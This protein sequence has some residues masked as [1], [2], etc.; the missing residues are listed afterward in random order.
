MYNRECRR[1]LGDE[2][3][4]YLIRGVG[5]GGRTTQF[6]DVPSVR[7]ASRSA[8]M[9]APTVMVAVE[10][11]WVMETADKWGPSDTWQVSHT[12]SRQD[13]L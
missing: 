3:L 5:F 2:F 4:C 13:A 12:Y 8:W 6:V 1:V 11:V 9:T 7:S 10:L